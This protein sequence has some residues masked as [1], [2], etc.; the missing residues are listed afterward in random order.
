MNLGRIEN[1]YGVALLRRRSK[2]CI[3]KIFDFENDIYA[4]RLNSCMARDNFVLTYIKMKIC[5]FKR[6]DYAFVFLL[7]IYS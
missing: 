5:I 6:L 4:K 1:S 2:I 7:F 3:S